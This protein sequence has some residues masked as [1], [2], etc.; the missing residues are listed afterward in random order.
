MR[1]LMR[2]VHRGEKGFT[3]IELL[4]VIA[5]LGIIAAV[6]IPNAAGF[7]TTG[8]LNAANTEVANVRTAATGFMAEHEGIWPEDSDDLGDYFEGG[9]GALKAL[10]TFGTDTTANDGTSTNNVSSIKSVT[11]V[12]DGWDLTKIEWSFAKQQWVRI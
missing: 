11:A 8:T 4:I 10:Y 6:V 9:T 2:R 12:A 5:I 1:R 7:M 3:L